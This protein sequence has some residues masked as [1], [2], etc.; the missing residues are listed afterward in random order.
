LLKLS[1]NTG[2]GIV[3]YTADGATPTAFQYLYII[4][5]D[6]Q[7]IGMTSPHSAE[8]PENAN[9]TGFG[10]SERGFLTFGG[11]PSFAVDINDGPEIFWAGLSHSKYMQELLYVKEVSE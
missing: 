9:M 11:K 2:S 5:D 3:S 10:M 7:P 4:E 1:T 6:V 8:M